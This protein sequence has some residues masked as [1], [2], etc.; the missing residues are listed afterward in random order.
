M[1]TFWKEK[2]RECEFPTAEGRRVKGKSQQLRSVNLKEVLTELCALLQEYA[3]TWYPEK[4]HDRALDA[5]RPRAEVLLE[6]VTL[7]EEYAPTWYTEKQRGRATDA[8]R[9]LEVLGARGGPG[10]HSD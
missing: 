2:E 8:L 3:P 5:R 7:L 9:V 6:L 1:P 4:Q 10:S